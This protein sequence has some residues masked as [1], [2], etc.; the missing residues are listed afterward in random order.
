MR[1][2]QLG[3]V[4]VVI[5]VEG[6]VNRGASYIPPRGSFKMLHILFAPQ[7]DFSNNSWLR[8]LRRESD[9]LKRPFILFQVFHIIGPGFSQL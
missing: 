2:L 7:E 1:V 5:T 8:R 3:I 9:F 6:R 4:F